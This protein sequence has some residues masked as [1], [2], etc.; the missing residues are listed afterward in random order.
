[1]K[2]LNVNDK[3]PA[4]PTCLSC[5]RDEHE[6]PLVVLAFSG[7]EARICPQCL[8]VLIHHV[9]RLEEKLGSLAAR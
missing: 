5:N 2:G 4:G 9:D 8:P 1:M 6:T 7:K 3:L